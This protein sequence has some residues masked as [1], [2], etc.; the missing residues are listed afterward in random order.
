M[1]NIPDIIKSLSARLQAIDYDQL[2][3]SDYNKQYIGNLKPAMLY[4]MKIYNACLSK[5]FKATGQAPEDITLVDYGGGSGF[6]SMLA[7]SIGVGKVIYLDLNPKS[8]ETIQVLKQET[9][10]GPDV[11]LHGNSD[12][13]ADWCKANRIQPD[14]LIATDLIEHVYDLKEFFKDLSILNPQMQMIFTTAS[15]PFNPYV[16]RR[17]HKLMDG[18]ET[19]VFE[20]PNYYTLRK[21]YIEQKYPHL[22]GEETDKWAHQ[23]RGLIYSDIDKAIKNNELPI[24]KDTHNTCDPA[25]GNWTERILPI[26][27]Y[28][29]ILAGYNYSLNVEKGFYNSDRNGLLSSA[30]CKCINWL[31]KISGKAGL[32]IAPFIFLSCPHQGGKS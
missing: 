30:I 4:Y 10:I 7:K 27:D 32:L 31:I 5:G 9:G 18:C 3:I 26:E 8:V 11:I 22:S 15:T 12:R 19:G 2:P 14:L 24:L 13:L 20:V 28:R 23:T 17:L 6:L 29:L 16:K 21:S 1:N 25:N